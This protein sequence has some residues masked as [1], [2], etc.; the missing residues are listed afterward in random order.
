MKVVKDKCVVEFN[1]PLQHYKITISYKLQRSQSWRR[2]T[3]CDCKIDWFWILSPLEEMKYLFKFI[4][5]FLRSGVEAKRGVEFRHSTAI[6][7]G[8]RIRRKVERGK[9][10][11][12]GYPT[13]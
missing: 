12:S 10:V 9:K 8:E 6:R 1:R 5:P 13:A 7:N 2:G 11:L 3:K 4:I